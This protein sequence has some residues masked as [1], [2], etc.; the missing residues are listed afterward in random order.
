MAF[1]L[2]SLKA[3]LKSGATNS[4]N[5]RGTCL[6]YGDWAPRPRVAVDS[7]VP[8]SHERGAQV[9]SGGVEG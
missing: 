7:E 6:E 3:A 5:R 4:K 8:A 2:V 1:S 9:P